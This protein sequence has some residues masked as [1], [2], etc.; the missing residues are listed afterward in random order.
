VLEGKRFVDSCARRSIGPVDG[1]YHVYE[2][3][4]WIRAVCAIQRGKHVSGEAKKVIA[5]LFIR[6][7]EDFHMSPRSFY[8]VRVS[9]SPRIDEAN[10]VIYS[11]ISVS[12]VTETP[13]CSPTVTN[14]RCA[15]FDPS[16]DDVE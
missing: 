12:V 8:Y 5:L 11:F 10:T 9:T 14:D 3:G 7:Q 15:R 16:V 4:E 13:I 1:P 6:I 2:H